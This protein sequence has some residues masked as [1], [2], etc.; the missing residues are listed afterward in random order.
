N[1]TKSIP[2]TFQ[3]AKVQSTMDKGD[4]LSSLVE[5]KT[6]HWLSQWHTARYNTRACSRRNVMVLLRTFFIASSSLT[7]FFRLL[8]CQLFKLWKALE[9]RTFK[10]VFWGLAISSS[11]FTEAFLASRSVNK[12]CCSGS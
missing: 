5:K 6:W 11:H 3:K 4:T 9:N 7:W 1:S 2:T 8:F 12:A 10:E